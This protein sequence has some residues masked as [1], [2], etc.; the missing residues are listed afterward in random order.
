MLA[1]PSNPT[2]KSSTLKRIAWDALLATAVTATILMV[3]AFVAALVTMHYPQ[4]LGL[5]LGDRYRT[6]LVGNG[7]I[8]FTIIRD[9]DGRTPGSLAREV[10]IGFSQVVAALALL[11]GLL[12][13][14]RIGTHGLHRVLLP[15]GLKLRSLLK[16]G[17]TTC[18]LVT[19]HEILR[20]YDANARNF[21]GLSGQTVAPFLMTPRPPRFL[22]WLPPA[23]FGALALPL[24]IA[25]RRARL[26]HECPRCRYDLTGNVSGI[27]PECGAPLDDKTREIVLRKST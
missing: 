23:V 20:T 18:F 14:A 25:D 16:I 27:C 19:A 10:Q 11:A 8:A 2:P 13:L 1:R 5:N 26:P 15:N 24:W 3:A 17:L 12:W 9:W 22:L 6:I 21:T 4:R 7:A